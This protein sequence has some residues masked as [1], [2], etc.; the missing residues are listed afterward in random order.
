MVL[1]SFTFIVLAYI[2][3]RCIEFVIAAITARNWF[4]AIAYGIV[5][6][7][8]LLGELVVLGVHLG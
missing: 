2:L 5:G 3:L 4:W 7:L 6:L 1:L 8:A